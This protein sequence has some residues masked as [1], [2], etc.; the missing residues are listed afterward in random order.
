[1]TWDVPSAT[2][3]AAKRLRFRYVKGLHRLDIARVTVEMD[4][5]AVQTLEPNGYAGVPSRNNVC[6]LNLP[7][8][9][10]GNNSCRIR[11]KVRG[12]GGNDSYGSVELL[13]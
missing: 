3:K 13:P 11:A 9:A 8:N 2:L 10:T 1:M 7:A 12:N 5:V 4:G 6:T